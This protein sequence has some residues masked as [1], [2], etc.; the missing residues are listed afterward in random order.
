M[1]NHLCAIFFKKD[2]FEFRGVKGNR[3]AVLREVLKTCAERYDAD[4]RAV[5]VKRIDMLSKSLFDRIKNEGYRGK[6]PASSLIF[7]SHVLDYLSN[8]DYSYII[9]HPNSLMFEPRAIGYTLKYVCVKASGCSLTATFPLEL[10]RDLTT[11][12]RSSDDLKHIRAS[13]FCKYSSYYFDHTSRSSYEYARSYDFYNKF[14]FFGAF[15]TEKNVPSLYQPPVLWVTSGICHGFRDQ[16]GYYNSN[17]RLEIDKNNVSDIFFFFDQ[18]KDSLPVGFRDVKS[19][20][21]PTIASYYRAPASYDNPTK[22]W[23]IFPSCWAFEHLC[24]YKRVKC[25]T[26]NFLDRAFDVVKIKEPFRFN[27]GPKLLFNHAISP[28]TR[29][30]TI[31]SV[32]TKVMGGDAGVDVDYGVYYDKGKLRVPRDMVPYVLVQSHVVHDESRTVIYDRNKTALDIL[33]T[34]QASYIRVFENS[35]YPG[36]VHAHLN[37][38]LPCLRRNLSPSEL[39]KAYRLGIIRHNPM[40]VCLILVKGQRDYDSK[41]VRSVGSDPEVIGSVT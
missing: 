13:T 6:V 16:D 9:R 33:S 32:I 28:V 14:K 18:Y 20:I 8:E 27:K 5:Y 23:V 40:N 7:A 37:K 17:L 38:V 10:K 2:D 15:S 25:Y 26:V 4:R 11:Y 35:D 1:S 34:L 12:I 21:P 3:L 31:D 19:I 24:Q 41:F 36:F 22:G 30:D 29:S 39:S